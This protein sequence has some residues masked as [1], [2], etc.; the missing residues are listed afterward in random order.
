MGMVMRNDAFLS[1]QY[2]SFASVRYM[3]YVIHVLWDYK[4]PKV[5]QKY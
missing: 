4:R 2:N 3:V 1:L 5:P